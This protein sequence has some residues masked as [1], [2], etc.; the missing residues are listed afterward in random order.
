MPAPV[1]TRPARTLP[2]GARLIALAPDAA[3]AVRVLALAG[4]GASLAALLPA[5]GEDPSLRI[6]R[7]A[8]T[9]AERI[10]SHVLGIAHGPSAGGLRGETLE[11]EAELEQL[12][13]ALPLAAARQMPTVENAS[14]A[15]AGEWMTEAALEA[16][17]HALMLMTHP[18]YEVVAGIRALHPA[19]TLARAA[20]RV[21]HVAET[22]AAHDGLLELEIEASYWFS[23]RWSAED[24]GDER[25]ER[26]VHRR[27]EW[28]LAERPTL[29]RGES[30]LASLLHSM[31]VAGWSKLRRQAARAL[32]R[33]VTGA[34]QVLERRAD[35]EV[36]RVRSL[37][38]N[39]ELHVR[40]PYGEAVPGRVL[41]G[42]ALP[43]GGGEHVF[44]LST[45]LV[46]AEDAS[47]LRAMAADV[48][49]FAARLPFAVALEATIADGLY[50]ARLPRPVSPAADPDDALLRL[51]EL[52]ARMTERGLAQPV[53]H[54][55]PVP[56][57]ATAE[58]LAVPSDAVLRAWVGALSGATG[59]VPAAPLR[60]PAEPRYGT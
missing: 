36:A 41:L 57:G 23:E 21:L 7:Q 40:D 19:E 29:A 4:E 55:G 45:E 16:H 52:H 48:R 35:G 25:G 51:E 43:S 39:R 37:T 28:A 58:L 1:L 60:R 22:W 10:V 31:E 59:S 56:G 14:L 30:V 11:L 27:M 49:A 18:E 42:R 44:A 5:D 17:G 24:D 34:F 20:E 15:L 32:V 47:D 3:H 50:G 26:S 33:S 8:A 2:A 13:R 53:E 9:L 38:D 12:R 6:A 46:S 54:P